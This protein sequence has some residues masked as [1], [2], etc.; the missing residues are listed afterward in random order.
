MKLAVIGAKGQLGSDIVKVLNTDNE[1]IPLT[2]D[3]MDITEYKAS[4][5]ILKDIE[6]EAVI[7]CA[8]Y[9]R[10][11]D[12][13][14]LAEKAFVVNALG[15]RNVA[16]IC[17]KLNA[18]LLHISTDY[19]FDGRKNIYNEEDIPNPVYGNSKLAGEY[20]VRNTLDKY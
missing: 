8:A 18:T 13:E 4:E 12:T 16:L 10:V 15:A 19:V 3:D 17:K 20:F 14:D 11:D 1:V 9:V 7:N 6:P 5:E 2:H